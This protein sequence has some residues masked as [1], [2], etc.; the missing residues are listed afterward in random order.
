MRTID[1]Y[2]L[3]SFGSSMVLWMVGLLVLR[4]LGDLFVNMDEFAERGGFA[5]VIAGILSYYGHHSLEYFAELGGIIIV[6]AAAF[7]VARMNHTNELTAMLASGMSLHR[8]VWPIIVC[9]MLLSGF[10]IIDKELAIPSVAERLSEDRDGKDEGR[11]KIF[12]VALVK[13]GPRVWYSSRFTPKGSRLDGPLYLFRNERFTLLAD[14]HSREYGV[15]VPA[16]EDSPAGWAMG[17]ARLTRHDKTWP[18]NPTTR[19]IYTSIGPEAIRRA[20]N[21]YVVSRGERL[22]RVIKSVTFPKGFPALQ[23]ATYDVDIRAERVEFA[24]IGRGGPTACKLVKPRFG[25]Y[26]DVAGQRE[27]LGEF[28]AAEATWSPS[29]D[30]SE[31]HWTLSDEAV[32][33]CPSDLTPDDLVMQQSERWMDLMSS[34]QL[35]RVLEGGWVSDPGEVLLTKYIRIADPVNVLVM[36]LLGLPFIL[37]R[38]RNIKASAMLCGL[39]VGTFYIF[40]FICRYMGLPPFMGAFLPILLF[41]PIAVVMLDAIKT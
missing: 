29:D 11:S 22:P 1:K 3:R 7:T 28:I 13:D 14:G 12:A 19:A 5:D 24:P 30:P 6:A 18:V 20:I 23:D 37:S 25:F 26:A 10:V 33:F 21:D 40:I 35:S 2:I 34:R 41:G 32:L 31:R 15:H 27:L 8:V 17:Q 16:G 38:E 4:V 39:M 9:A 36:L